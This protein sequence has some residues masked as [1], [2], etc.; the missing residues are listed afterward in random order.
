[1]SAAG[2]TW[3]TS[4]NRFTCDAGSR[5]CRLVG[6]TNQDRHSISNE[7]PHAAANPG[8]GRHGARQA[9]GLQAVGARGAVVSEDD[10]AAA[11]GES[12]RGEISGLRVRELAGRRCGPDRQAQE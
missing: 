8:A 3:L 4:W 1:M 9:I 11:D 6:R 12:R 10:A 2:L 5:A 7:T